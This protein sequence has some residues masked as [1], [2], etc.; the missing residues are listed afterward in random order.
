MTARE[1]I[2]ELVNQELKEAN[3]QYPLFHSPHEAY[4]VLKEEVEELQYNAG[5]LESLTGQM[6][7]K[8]KVDVEI[9]T[10]TDPIHAQAVNAAMEAIQIAAMC[11][12]IKQSNLYDD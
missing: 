9:E 1:K 8:V 6:W 7:A 5:R 2:F 11:E 4:A 12:K 3:E 10:I